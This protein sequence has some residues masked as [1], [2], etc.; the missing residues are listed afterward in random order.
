MRHNPVKEALLQGGVSIG[1]MVFEFNTSGIAHLAAG[2][3]AE[4]IIYDMEH[5]GWSIETIRIIIFFFF[6]KEVLRCIPEQ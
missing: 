1:T 2:A 3:G 6:I 4:F 5:T